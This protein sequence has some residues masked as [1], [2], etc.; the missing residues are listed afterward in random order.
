MR[1]ISFAFSS[2]AEVCICRNGQLGARL[3]GALTWWVRILSC[4]ISEM[5]PWSGINESACHI[6]VD[7]ASSP[8][9]CAA[10]L[11]AGGEIWFTDL[12][13]KGKLWD[14]FCKRRDKQIM[15]LVLALPLR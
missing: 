10:V 9:R 15:G 13:V 2:H 12:A 5:R 1:C 4:H 8:A 6:F 11:I 14:L 3:R 7:A